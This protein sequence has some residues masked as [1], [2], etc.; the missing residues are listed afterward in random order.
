MKV[1]LRAIIPKGSPAAKGLSGKEESGSEN[2]RNPLGHRLIY[3]LDGALGSNSS[4][5]LIGGNE[6]VQYSFISLTGLH[7]EDCGQLSLVVTIQ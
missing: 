5:F 6:S 7:L 4:V 2:G 3:D 1:R